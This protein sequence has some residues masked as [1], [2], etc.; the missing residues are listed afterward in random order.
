MF[1]LPGDL[2]RHLVEARVDF[3]N[4]CRVTLTPDLAT[5]PATARKNTARARLAALLREA[6]ARLRA[7]ASLDDA[8][9]NAVGFRRPARARRHVAAPVDRPILST[10]HAPNPHVVRLCVRP[11]GT[12]SFLVP[13]DYRQWL[14]FAC[15]G[16]E[17]GSP[18]PDARR[19]AWRAPSR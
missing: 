3:D 4:A 7:D 16:R 10:K 9:L 17:T 19:A 1:R 5:R 8:A 18:P 2:V 15:V 6:A 12:D 13:R 14:L 11:E